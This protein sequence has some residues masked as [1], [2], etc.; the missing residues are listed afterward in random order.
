[1]MVVVGRRPAKTHSLHYTIKPSPFEITWMQSEVCVGDTVSLCL[2]PPAAPASLCPSLTVVRSPPSS[3]FSIQH[4][5]SST[6]RHRPSFV[7]A[8]SQRLSL[9]KEAARCQV[10][11]P[12]SSTARPQRHRSEPDF[13]FLSFVSAFVYLIR[14]ESET[15]EE[16]ASEFAINTWAWGVCGNGGGECGGFGAQR[17]SAAIRSTCFASKTR[18]V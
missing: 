9:V 14:Y 4:G 8:L 12:Y 1:M 6:S 2:S 3:A 13:S 5:Y 17:I 7:C 11:P 10:P 15:K 18:H 16:R